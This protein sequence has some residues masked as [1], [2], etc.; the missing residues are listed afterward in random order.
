MPPRAPSHNFEDGE[1][2]RPVVKHEKE[3][4]EMLTVRERS[5]H[6]GIFPGVNFGL[7]SWRRMV[8][9]DED[10]ELQMPC[11]S[12]PADG[13][14]DIEGNRGGEDR[15]SLASGGDTSR[16]CG[17]WHRGSAASSVVG[18]LFGTN[19]A[20]AVAVDNGRGVGVTRAGGYSGAG[21]HSG[22]GVDGDE[23]I[24]GD[25]EDTT[26]MEDRPALRPLHPCIPNVGNATD[27]CSKLRHVAESLIAELL[28]KHAAHTTTTAPIVAEVE[29]ASE[30]LSDI[31]ATSIAQ[32]DDVA[33]TSTAQIDDAVA[34]TS[35]A[36]TTVAAT[37][38]AVVAV[39][40]AAAAN[41]AA[42]KHTRSWSCER[43]S[44]SDSLNV[45]VRSNTFMGLFR[46][47]DCMILCACVSCRRAIRLE[48]EIDQDKDNTGKLSG[49]GGEQK[50][51]RPGLFL[52]IM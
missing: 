10:G 8:D 37:A 44:E 2:N 32:V 38:A 49:C 42:K 31:A 18:Q 29:I 48:E 40:A 30:S 16:H 7:S 26:V 50:K 20:A 3:E 22:S 46:P 11:G 36:A 17:Q 51:A 34:D 33:A 12:F 25:R 5:G 35:I 23:T 1:L 13:D 9:K 52:P 28:D 24:S 45:R 19:S 6:A 43:S 14:R 15:N 39:T 47:R 21:G 4:D 27:D 41:T